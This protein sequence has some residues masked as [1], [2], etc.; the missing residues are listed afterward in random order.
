MAGAHQPCRPIQGRAVV[1][2]V[3]LLGRAGVQRHPHPDGA[4]LAPRLGL[5][6]ALGIQRRRDRVRGASEHGVE[7]V[8]HRLDDVAAVLADRRSDRASWRARATP[9]RLGLVLPARG[10]ALDVR[11][12]ERHCSARQLGHAYPSVPTRRRGTGYP[13]MIAAPSSPGRL[14]EQRA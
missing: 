10:A 9:H 4:D 2:A 12:Q 5:E 8:A 6:P 1:V 13:V 7:G 3:P 14:L 11:E